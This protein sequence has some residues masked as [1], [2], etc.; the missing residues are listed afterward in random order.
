M[1]YEDIPVGFGMALSQN[2][3][4]LRVFMSLSEKER[5]RVIIRTASI[6]SK[7]EMRQYVNR[8]VESRS[9]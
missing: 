9:S 5:S 2:P 4:G 3:N 6:S 7:E 8:L 1:N